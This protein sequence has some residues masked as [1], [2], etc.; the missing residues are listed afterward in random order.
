MGSPLRPAIAGV[1]VAALERSLIP[2]L[3]E[4]PASWKLYVDKTFT[5]IRLTLIE[6]V[7]SALNIFH[8]NSKFN[9]N[10]KVKLIFSDVLLKKDDTFEAAIHGVSTYNGKY[11]QRKLFA[12]ISW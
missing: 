7:F 4:H 8:Q 10:V 12:R 3:I 1:F 5:L 9:R 2:F 11:L 6:R